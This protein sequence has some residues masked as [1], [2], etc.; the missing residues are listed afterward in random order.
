MRPTPFASQDEEE[1]A[2]HYDGGM[3]QRKG[4]D[5]DASRPQQDEFGLEEGCLPLK[6]GAKK[7]KRGIS[8][9]LLIALCAVFICAMVAYY[10][11]IMNEDELSGAR[12][13]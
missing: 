2:R 13:W 7:K 3:T 8:N 6:S 4:K 12:I 9:T 1:W 11:L 5:S 10:F